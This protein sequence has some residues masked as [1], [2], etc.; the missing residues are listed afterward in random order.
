M[1][2]NETKVHDASD[3]NTNNHPKETVTYTQVMKKQE[4]TF[5]RIHHCCQL[6]VLF[7]YIKAFGRHKP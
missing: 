3:Y 4:A 7:C 1:L 6:M 5:I 2:T